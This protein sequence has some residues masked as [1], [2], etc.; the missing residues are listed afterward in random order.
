M[1]TL[2]KI[3]AIA[4]GISAVALFFVAMPLKYIWH[5]DAYIRPEGMAHGLLVVVYIIIATILKADLKWSW[6]KYLVV[7]LA[8]IPPG[9]TFFVHGKYISETPNSTN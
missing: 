7:C 2:F 9:G 4:E 5:D 1:T 6:K 3:V 8:S